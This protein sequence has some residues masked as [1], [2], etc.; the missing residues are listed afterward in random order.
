L[1]EWPPRGTC[2]SRLEFQMFRA[3]RIK[4]EATHLDRAQRKIRE[5]LPGH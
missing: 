3:I 4:R 2:L 5:H 1:T